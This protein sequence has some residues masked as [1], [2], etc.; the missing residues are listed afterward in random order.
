MMAGMTTSTVSPGT[1]QLAAVVVASPGPGLSAI[2]ER[3]AELLRPFDA[4]VRVDPYSRPC[5]CVGREAL[6]WAK[7]EVDQRDEWQRERFEAVRAKTRAVHLLAWSMDPGN[8]HAEV[9]VKRIAQ[10]DGTVEQLKEL[11]MWPPPSPD[12]VALADAELE[13]EWDDF[14]RAHRA[15]IDTLAQT[16]ALYGLPNPDCGVEVESSQRDTQE[17]C[18]GSG[19]FLTTTNPQ[20]RW[21]RWVAGGQFSAF[22]ISD[23]AGDLLIDPARAGGETHIMATDLYLTLL[24]DRKVGLPFALVTD[25]GDWL[26]EGD[27]EVEWRRT[28]ISTLAAARD[29]VIVAVD[30]T[31][32][33][34]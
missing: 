7:G 6:E 26:E 22:F 31:R 19:H 27:S 28:V 34:T 17:V 25:A 16:H 33:V 9:T 13:A 2:H 32:A 29:A 12:A 1:H 23:E 11:G 5:W 8:P 3:V 15:A 4:G 10:A 20:G 14:N 30:V 24:Q 21:E 18:G